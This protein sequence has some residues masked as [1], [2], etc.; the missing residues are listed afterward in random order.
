MTDPNEAGD[1]LEE[2]ATAAYMAGREGEYLD[3]LAHRAH[4]GEGEP[5]AALRCAFWLGV[6]LARR[7][8]TGAAGGWLGRAQRLL[9]SEGEDR[10]EHGYL[11]LPAV[12]EREARGEWAKAAAIA[13]EAT[14]IGE[15][16][17]DADLFALAGHEQG[18]A[19]IRA[20]EVAAGLSLLDQ[21]MVAASAGELSPIVTGDRLLRRDPRLRAG[22]RRAPRPRVDRDPEPL[23]RRTA[24]D[25][26]LHRPLPDSPR[27]DHAVAGS[28]DGGAGGGAARG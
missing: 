2:L 5:I 28:V 25:G 9:E 24:G 23:V 19:L 14:A 15:R 12:F 18:Q 26:R 8:E 13:G 21:A 10:V 11:L 7:G 1:Q 4:L 16:F 17:G 6:N 3:L 22:A 20:G 27:R